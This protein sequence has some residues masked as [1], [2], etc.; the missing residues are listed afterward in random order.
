MPSKETSCPSC[1]APIVF[2]TSASIMVVCEYCD[3]TVVRQDVNLDNVG[4]MAHLAEDASP[5]YR[6]MRGTVQGRDFIVIG[7]LQLVYSQGFWNEWFIRFDQENTAW[8]GEAAG[9]YLLFQASKNPGRVP[10]YDRIRTGQRIPIGKR[11]YI[12]SD[13]RTATCVSGEG[14]LPFRVGSGY[15]FTYVD[16]VSHSKFVATIDY[17]DSNPLQFEGVWKDFD[18]FHFHQPRTFA[19]WN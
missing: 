12:V 3:T 10:A 11:T 18:S 6:G 7:R 4:K 9:E 8:I 15:E 16:L 17:S 1:G 13:F 5:L 2:T 19:G 14:E